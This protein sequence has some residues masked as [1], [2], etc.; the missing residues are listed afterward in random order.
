[1]HNHRY[2]ID[3]LYAQLRDV[4]GAEGL[5]SELDRMDKVHDKKG[6]ATVLEDVSKFFPDVYASVPEAAAYVVH[7]R[8]PDADHRA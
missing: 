2:I 8:K 4:E 6:M 1:M 5:R 7:V 3:K